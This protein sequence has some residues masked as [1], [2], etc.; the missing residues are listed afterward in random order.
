ML[1]QATVVPPA[2]FIAHAGKM[3]LTAGLSLRGR[4]DSSLAAE[5][6][7]LAV[8]E[9]VGYGL[10][11]I[12]VDCQRLTSLSAHGC[13]ALYHAHQYAQYTDTNLYWCGLAP[14]LTVQLAETGLHLL[15]HLLPTASYRGPAA[16]LQEAVPLTQHSLRFAT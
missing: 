11:C 5:K 7:E 4:C 16:L 15:L 2:A 1:T 13:R 3:G 8:N 6:L 9:A 10:S 14:E 12:W